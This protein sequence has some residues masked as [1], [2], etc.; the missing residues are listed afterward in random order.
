MLCV[1]RCCG[2]CKSVDV[3]SVFVCVCDSWTGC[4]YQLRAVSYWFGHRTYQYKKRVIW[5]SIHSVRIY[6][7]PSRCFPGKLETPAS[8]A[9]QEFPPV[10]LQGPIE[11]GTPS[12]IQSRYIPGAGPGGGMGGGPHPPGGMPGHPNAGGGFGHRGGG[13]PHAHGQGGGFGAHREG[14]FNRFGPPGGGGNWHNA[15][16]G[17]G[18]A[19]G[20]AGFGMG[21][22]GMGRKRFR[23]S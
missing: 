16:P 2:E 12:V 10:Y 17:G 14:G 8:D 19:P 15:G 22:G 21:D 20:A 13:P 5:H 6:N 4:C 1:L 9:V 11:P 23:E 3:Y 18:G 7:G